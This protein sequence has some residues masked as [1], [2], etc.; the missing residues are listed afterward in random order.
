MNCDFC[1]L[2]KEGQDAGAGK[3]IRMQSTVKDVRNARQKLVQCGTQ[4]SSGRSVLEPKT[5]WTV[6]CGCMQ[7]N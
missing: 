2:G 1:L 6:C 7:A 5:L 4:V 3:G